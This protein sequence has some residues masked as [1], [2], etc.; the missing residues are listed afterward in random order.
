MSQEKFL[1]PHTEPKLAR[2]ALPNLN[3]RQL[4]G[5]SSRESVEP[6]P[7]PVDSGSRSVDGDH[8]HEPRHLP[9]LARRSVAKPLILVLSPGAPPVLKRRSKQSPAQ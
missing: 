5:I 2:I 3:R 7:P 9:S 6:S 8:H 4:R 1:S